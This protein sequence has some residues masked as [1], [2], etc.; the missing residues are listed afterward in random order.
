[1]SVLYSAFVT[2][3]R[4]PL[5]FLFQ[6]N[7]YNGLMYLLEIVDDKDAHGIPVSNIMYWQAVLNIRTEYISSEVFFQ[8]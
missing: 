7:G 6:Y 8:K 3:I 5:G 2:S 4:V 1:M